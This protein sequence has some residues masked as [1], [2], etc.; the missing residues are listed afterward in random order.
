MNFDNRIKIFKSTRHF[1]FA[2]KASW[3]ISYITAGNCSERTETSF[4]LRK[5]NQFCQCVAENVHGYLLIC[6][7]NISQLYRLFYI[8]KPKCIGKVT[9]WYYPLSYLKC[10]CAPLSL[11]KETKPDEPNLAFIC[12]W[13][14]L[15]HVAIPGLV[16]YHC[17][18]SG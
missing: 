17:L 8:I 9:N 16:I 2:L 12:I 18:G 4:P 1:N 6:V 3:H 7:G 5:M 10:M 13:N 14:F 11:P 15:E